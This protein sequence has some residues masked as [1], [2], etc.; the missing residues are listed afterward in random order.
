M[1]DLLCLKKWKNI[2]AITVTA[3]YIISTI[4]SWI[5]PFKAGYDLERISVLYLPLAISVI[6][7]LLSVI[8][9]NFI[10]KLLLPVSF[11]VILAIEILVLYV[12]SIGVYKV[13]YISDIVF[14]AIFL[15]GNLLCL[16]ASLLNNTKIGSVVVLSFGSIV[17]AVSKAIH[18]IIEYQY[19]GG[20]YGSFPEN[21]PKFNV[22]ICLEFVLIILL[23]F[24]I[25]I[26]TTNVFK[27]QEKLGIPQS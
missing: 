20:F 12:C 13:D 2:V 27:K 23:Y 17:C 16:L 21:T 22:G 19:A 18:M 10:N 5:M 8:K 9:K 26:L 24:S 25:F 3:L 7:L 1:N 6:L 11:A 14:S 15:F 4:Y